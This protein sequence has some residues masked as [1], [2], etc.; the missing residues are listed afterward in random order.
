[1]IL[2]ESES[3]SEN[4]SERIDL[5]CVNRGWRGAAR[6]GEK[7]NTV[8]SFRGEERRG[9]ERR[10]EGEEKRLTKKKRMESM[11]NDEN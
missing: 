3:E 8:R 6:Q 9:E 5:R 10:G 4:E 11:T 2:S 7:E 1:M